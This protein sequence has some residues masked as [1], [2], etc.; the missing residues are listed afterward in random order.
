MLA[1]V[2]VIQSNQ[3]QNTNKA[4]KPPKHKYGEYQNVL[5]SDDDIAKLKAKW[6]DSYL[7]KIEQL[8]EGIEMKGYKYKN[9]YL[10][11]LKWN[12]QEDS[13]AEQRTYDLEAYEE[14]DFLEP[15][16]EFGGDG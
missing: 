14:M 13:K 3:N 7:Q 9:H 6:P 4:G 10:A 15:F 5:L 1:N 16:P 2:P 12:K 11:L 8:S